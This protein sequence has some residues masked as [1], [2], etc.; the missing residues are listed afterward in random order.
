[1]E[2]EIHREM[3]ENS[4]VQTTINNKT[5]VDCVSPAPTWDLVTRKA[6]PHSVFETNCSQCIP[7]AKSKKRQVFQMQRSS[8]SQT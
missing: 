7:L 4:S 5:T 2:N 3:T 8:S 6:I 1:M